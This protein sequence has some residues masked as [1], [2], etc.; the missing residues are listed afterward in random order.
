MTAWL[1]PIFSHVCSQNP[2]HTWS[3]GGVV[4]P[5][6]Q[7]CTG[8]YVGACVAAGLHGIVRPVPTIRWR[9]AH[10]GMLL[11]MVPFGF[12]WLPQGPALRAVS[13][14]FFGFGLVAFL[15]L[16]LP[17]SARSGSIWW[18]SGGLLAT[19]VSVPVLGTRRNVLAAD[20]LAWLAAGGALVLCGL[21]SVSFFLAARAAARRASLPVA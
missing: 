17:E 4:L 18:Y 12:H 20:T 14:V 15:C 19:A 8:L 21:V 16:P 2:A 6:C 10:G 1:Q 3:V 13:G 11:A 9:W 7:R 5:C